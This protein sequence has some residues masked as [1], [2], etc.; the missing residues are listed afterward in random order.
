MRKYNLLKNAGLIVLSS[1]LLFSGCSKKNK[2]QKVESGKSELDS[3]SKFEVTESRLT[4]ELLWKFGRVGDAQLSPDGKTVIYSVTRYNISENKGYTDVFSVS[5]DGKGEAKQL[6]NFAGSEFNARWTSNGKK[7]GFIAVES[8][9][10]QIWEMNS[11]GSDQ[12]KISEI[13]G[14][15]N[16]FE[17][18]P[19]ATHVLYTMDVKLD[20][21]INDKYPDLPKAEAMGFDNLMYRHWDNW[22]DYKYSHVFVAEIKNNTIKKSKDI[23]KGEQFDSPLSPY[24][25][26][27]EISWSNDGKFIAYTCKKLKGRDY[28]LSTNSDIFV[29][30]IEDGKTINISETNLGYDKLP[31]F[32]KDSKKIAWQ[33]MKTPGFESDKGRLMVYDLSS[34][35]SVDITANFDQSTSSYAWSDDNASIYFVSAIKATEQ[36]YKADIATKTITQITKGVHDYTSVQRSSGVL[37]GSK[38]SMSMATEVFKIDEKS[39]QETQL[40]YT[41][42]K[43]YDKVEMGRVEERWVKTTDNKDML[44][45]VIYPPKFDSTKKYPAILFCQGGPQS[46]VSQF[47]SYRWN[48]QMMAANDYIV[49]A[50]NRRGLPSF[51][52]EWNDQISL[53]YGGQNMKDYLSAVDAIA[54]LSYVDKNNLGCV[55]PSYGGFSVYWLAGHHQK[56]FKAFIA[57]C[58]MYNLESQYGSTEEYFFVNHDLGGAYWQNPKPKSYDF[59]PHKYI[60]NWDTPIMMISGGRDFRIPYTQ[61]MEAFNAAQLRGIPSRFLFFPNETHFVLKP[62]NSILWQREFFGW[63]DKWLKKKI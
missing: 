48:F 41:N 11:D 14:D 15:I 60:Q 40:T 56:R 32:S 62:Q 19:K 24:F 63:L 25:D 47:F 21:S 7:I 57:H 22:T 18:S 10:A 58:G 53:D 42:K 16:S 3:L 43:I 4:P 45:W 39:G 36:I 2:E 46:A 51:G 13:D 31:V 34:K 59:S 28:A 33:S 50:P 8:G 23:M 30:N 12:K 52:S 49:I 9:S 35:T 29:Y 20:T 26:G 61:S 1:A 37:I 5:T 54:K 6:T 17:Y 55:G 44:V 27:A 38:M